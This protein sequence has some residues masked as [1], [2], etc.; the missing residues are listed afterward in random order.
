VVRTRVGYAGGRRASPTYRSLGDHTEAFQVD[1]DP[2]K[3]SFE[4]LLRVFWAEHDPTDA[5][6][7]IQYRAILFVA[8]DAQ[9]T[10]AE[11]SRKAVAKTSRGPVAT[12][13]VRLDRFWPAEDYHQ[14][15]A[16]RNDR[17]LLAELRAIY[18][19]DRDLRESSAAMRCNAYLDGHGTLATFEA[20]V[21]AL[22]LS[23]AGARYLRR[24]VAARA[25]TGGGT[26]PVGGG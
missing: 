14:K 16:L 25:G 5:G 22:G 10:A 24:V 21:G 23:D 26:C 4:A 13:I 11:G 17:V 12:P 19:D 6:V 3:T 9:A 2:S 8:D 7:P 1:F 15:Y 20:E 18:P